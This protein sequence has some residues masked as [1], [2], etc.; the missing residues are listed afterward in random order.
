MVAVKFNGLRFAGEYGGWAAWL[1][2]LSAGLLGDGWQKPGS[3]KFNPLNFHRE[4]N[5]S[6]SP[7]H[8]QLPGC[9][10]VE[11]G[12]VWDVAAEIPGLLAGRPIVG[13]PPPLPSPTQH[14]PAFE[15][16]VAPARALDQA[17]STRL[18]LRR[19]SPLSARFFYIFRNCAAIRCAVLPTTFEMRRP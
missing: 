19:C 16:V 15:W 13:K 3:W 1:T 5:R 9:V 18:V 17:R 7:A 2:M 12:F 11:C 10:A 6:D 4:C 8:R 14:K